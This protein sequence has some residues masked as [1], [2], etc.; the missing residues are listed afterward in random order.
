MSFSLELTLAV[1]VIPKYKSYIKVRKIDNVSFTGLH[2]CKGAHILTL[3]VFLWWK[4]NS[5]LCVVEHF[6][7]ILYSTG[8]VMKNLH[9]LYTTY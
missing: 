6:L 2:Y 4:F 1:L 8:I 3:T 7:Y 9:L 5:A